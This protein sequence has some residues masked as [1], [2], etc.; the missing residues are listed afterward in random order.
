MYVIFLGMLLMM[1]THLEDRKIIGCLTLITLVAIAVCGTLAVGVRHGSHMTKRSTDVRSTAV[2]VISG[3]AAVADHWKGQ[4]A[5]P[6]ESSRMRA[7]TAHNT[8][9]VAL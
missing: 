8:R 3:G 6:G 4:G 7:P 2:S 5:N 1:V 9:T